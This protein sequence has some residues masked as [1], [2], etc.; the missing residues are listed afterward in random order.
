MQLLGLTWAD[1][2]PETIRKSAETL[3]ATQMASGGWSEL[4]Y[5]DAD[6][7]S[8]GEAL[9]ALSTSGVL[10]PDSEAYERAVAFLLKAQRADGSWFVPSRLHPP[11]PVSP[12]YFEAG[13]PYGHDQFISIMGTTWAVTALAE[14]LPRVHAKEKPVALNVPDPDPWME[15]A[16]FGTADELGKML[17]N[18]LDP[19]RATPNGTSL[20]MLASPDIAKVRLLVEHGADVNATA[21][22]GY[23]ALLTAASY[24]GSRESVRYLLEHGAR[25][26]PEKRPIF[27][28]SALTNA[29]PAGDLEL[30][31]LLL[32]AGASPTQSVIVGE[33][34]LMS[35]ADMA[36]TYA[37]PEIL[38]VLLK[39]GADA[40]SHSSGL[41]LLSWAVI[42]NDLATV[43][44]LLRAGARINEIDKLG[45]AP[46]LYGA[47]L[48]FGD[49]E[50]VK[51]LLR[52]GAN[53]AVR[54]AQ[55]LSPGDL[56]LKYHHV[57]I[58][59]VLQRSA[60]VSRP[61]N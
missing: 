53:P 37:A 34:L 5:F 38:A 45:M 61:H 18:G 47:A 54:D 55:G 36:Q 13:F 30:I 35:P 27:N 11:A 16:L 1:A 32:N 44:V 42:K 31:R 4:P 48:D 49:T 23:T 24:G 12:P 50:V 60:I 29:I 46:L 21:K 26:K 3:L 52:N 22:T 19:N 9:V 7:Y 6:A 10:K 58:A 40:N 17:D 14:T 20:L 33:T 8:T 56:A 28:A 39:A 2:P 43:E 41:S 25:L 51:L 59:D 57:L 15:A